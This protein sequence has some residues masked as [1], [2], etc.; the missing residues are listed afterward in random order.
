MRTQAE[1]ALENRKAVAIAFRNLAVK[2]RKKEKRVTIAYSP[3]LCQKHLHLLSNGWWD[4][5]SLME[6]FTPFS[7]GLGPQAAG[8][9]G[10]MQERDIASTVEGTANP[11]FFSNS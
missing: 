8:L 11:H 3:E 7:R 5:V 1:A 2:Q 10:W 4:Q 6:M 9:G